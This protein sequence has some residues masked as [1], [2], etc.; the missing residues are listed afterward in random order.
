V[1]FNEA[2]ETRLIVD[3]RRWND[4]KDNKDKFKKGNFADDEVH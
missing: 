3:E 4:S 2:V 1:Q